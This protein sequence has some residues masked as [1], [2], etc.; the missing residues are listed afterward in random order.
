[1]EFSTE[2]FQRLLDIFKE[3]GAEYLKRLED[4]LLNLEKNPKNITILEDIFRNAHNLKGA[5]RILGL[6]E[7]AAL[8][9]ELESAFSLAKDGKLT[10][11]PERVDAISETIDKINGLMNSGINPPFNPS[12]SPLSKGGTARGVGGLLEGAGLLKGET[13][14]IKDG[15]AKIEKEAVIETVGK[16]S[17]GVTAAGMDRQAQGSVRVATTRLD[18]LMNQAG[19]LL[20]AK[21][22]FEQRM[23]D[24]N[25]LIT[26]TENLIKG[27]NRIRRDEIRL[28]K[29]G[30]RGSRPHTS[31]ARLGVL[32]FTD[33]LTANLSS[34]NDRL[35]RFSSEFY[36]NNIDLSNITD[37]LQDSVK[38][39][40]ML[41]LSTI[42]KTQQKMVRDLTR[43]LNKKVE[44]KIEG[45][46]IELDKRILEGLKDPFVHLITNC[47]D[48]GIE[49]PD[50]RRKA[51]KGEEGI[52]EITATAK[53]SFVEIVIRDDGRGMSVDK[54]RAKAL[55]KGIVTEETLSNL[56]NE[57]IINFIF[58]HG[59]STSDIITDVSGRGVGMDVVKKNIEELNGMIYIQS[60]SGKGCK[61]IIM[62]PLTLAT[63]KALLM[64]TGTETVA[65]PV[66]V[67]DRIMKVKADDIS[68]IEGNNAFKY[69]GEIIPVARM[70][71]ALGFKKMEGDKEVFPVVIIGAGE[72]RTAFIVDGFIGEE[73]IILKNLTYPLTK[74]RNVAGV[75]LLGDGRI[76][77]ILNPAELIDSMTSVKPAPIRRVMENEMQR[78]SVLV[79]DD[80]ITTRTME[81][82]ILESSGY[83]VTLAVDGVDAYN[84]LQGKRFDIIVLDV[85]MPNMDGFEFTE[86]VRDTPA[87]NDIPIILLTSL[88]KDED[89][90]RGIDVGANA[91]ITKRTFNQSNLLETIKRLI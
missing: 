75:A 56:S 41:P 31:T 2:D 62:V 86:K 79:V 78:Q 55:K 11:T 6:T 85:Q 59:F 49:S 13:E 28:K 83:D 44:L 89:K 15:E 18:D 64:R 77:V 22:K 34:F 58:E 65:L 17:E 52:I 67:I 32:Q 69:E 30:L 72:K 51:G 74:V 53:G 35:I 61:T 21:M 16:R 5:A 54:I 57:Q 68:M 48:H 43:R 12:I 37:R 27:F 60:E 8:A 63:V 82:N 14:A 3:E 4:G 9:H 26:L 24:V 45:E 90:R 84:K 40:R 47:I 19:E 10:I 70:D 73:T 23:E 87:L 39:I 76:A 71:Q 29:T 91:Y 88:E 33:D 7:I 50:E 36:E 80:S 42:L 20:V 1:M 66:T 81:K 46:G 38:V 25:S